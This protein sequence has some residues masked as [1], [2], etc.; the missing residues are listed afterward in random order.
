MGCV[1]GQILEMTSVDKPEEQDGLISD[2]ELLALM[3]SPLVASRLDSVT[4]M[5]ELVSLL[6]AERVRQAAAKEEATE[7]SSRQEKLVDNEGKGSFQNI[8]G[9]TS[10]RQQLLLNNLVTTPSPSSH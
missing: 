10:E 7:E 8:L 9:P 2:A 5:D 4:S 6:N 1:G 3:S